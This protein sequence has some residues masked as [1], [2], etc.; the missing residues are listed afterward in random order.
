MDVTALLLANAV[1][2]G[3]ILGV[4]YAGVALG[5]AIVFGMLDIPNLAHPALVILGAYV[6][7][8]AATGL[9]IDP[10]LASLL[11]SPLF[12]LIGMAIFEIYHW[13]FERRGTNPVL[14]ISFFFGLLFVTD[15]AMLLAFGANL[16]EI[17]TTYTRDNLDLLGISV[18]YRIL[19]P[20]F[21][22]AAIIGAT[23]L[24][25]GRTFFGRALSAVTQ[26]RVAAVLQSI[27]PTRIKRLASGLAA[28]VTAPM[29]AALLI[30]Q[31]IDPSLGREYIGR[32]FAICV[33]GGLGSISGMFIAA[34]LLGIAESVTASFLG[35]SWSPAVSFGA[36]VLTLALRPAGLLGRA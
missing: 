25:L 33:L 15:V 20:C 34:I 21:V 36:L 29:G 3:L 26:D 27:N 23:Y 9:G 12:F 16:R 13:A 2:V 22:S 28:A 31:P 8:F 24:F 35:P 32:I 17:S 18:P 7:Y 4:F 5:L 30:I 1:I 11:A 10:L 14:G 19:V 6:A